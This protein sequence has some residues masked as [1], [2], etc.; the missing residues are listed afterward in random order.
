LTED[1]VFRR[2]KVAYIS[3]CHYFGKADL[4]A[5]SGERREEG[6]EEQRLGWMS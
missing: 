2:V 5:V 3:K 1:L 6:D 4:R